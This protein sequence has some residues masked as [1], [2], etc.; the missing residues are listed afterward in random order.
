[1]PRPDFEQQML[2]FGVPRIFTATYEEQAARLNLFGGQ[3]RPGERLPRDRWIPWDPG[4][5]SLVYDWVLAAFASFAERL[6]GVPHVREIGFYQSHYVNTNDPAAPMVADR[7]TVAQ[8]G[9]GTMAIYQSVIRAN[10]HPV[11][12]SA[13]RAPAELHRPNEEGAVRGNVAHE[14]GHG[15]VETALT[16]G[17]GRPAPDAAFMDGYRRAAGWTAGEPP[18]LYDASVAEVRSALR[19]GTPPPERY[20]ITVAR[21]NEA[22]G[23]QPVTEYSV[24][25][26][27]EDVAEAL[28]MYVTAPDLLS[29]RSPRRFGFL[30]AHREVLRPHLHR[31]PG[32]ARP[33]PTPDELR[34]A[35]SLP[36]WTQPEPPAAAPD[37]SGGYDPAQRR[38]PGP[39]LQVR[40]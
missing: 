40:F 26:P 32:I 34:R 5:D 3:A 30:E 14:L 8:F 22:W 27:S 29:R 31:D 12:R 25:H 11:G 23:E 9:G 19:A 10:V 37:R 20:L 33:A 13:N 18:L 16:G 21:W 24:G 17:A 35:S 28:S 2:R 4:A 38:V 36:R 6:G 15:W 39:T 7:G 1:M